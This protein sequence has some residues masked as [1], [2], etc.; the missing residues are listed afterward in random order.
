MCRVLHMPKSTYYKSHHYTPS[1]R[2]LENEK[3]KQNILEIYT[4]SNRRYGAPKIQKILE[5]CGKYVSIKRVQRFMK[6]L[7]IHSIVI[8]KFRPAKANKKVM[9]RENLLK[10]DFTTTKIN[11]KWVGDITHTF[12]P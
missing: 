9:E 8:K 4:E 3:L 6:Q 10:Q 2:K 5:Q 11:E 1:R 12:T 7:N